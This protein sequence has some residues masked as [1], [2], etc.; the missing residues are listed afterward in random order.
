MYLQL[1]LK[2]LS[3]YGS[4]GSL[5]TRTMRAKPEWFPSFE[6]YV[7][8]QLLKLANAFTENLA[9]KANAITVML[10]TLLNVDKH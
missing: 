8:R 1:A 4:T 6:T 5:L 2:E 3:V 7:K 9:T 10:A